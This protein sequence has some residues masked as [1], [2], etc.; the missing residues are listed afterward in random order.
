MLIV[1]CLLLFFFWEGGGVLSSCTDSSFILYVV[2]SCGLWFPLSLTTL[3]GV[4]TEHLGFGDFTFPSLN[5]Y[6]TRR[7]GLDCASLLNLLWYLS[8]REEFKMR[9]FFTNRWPLGRGR[10]C[11]SPRYLTLAV[12]AF[13]LVLQFL[14][15]GVG[16]PRHRLLGKPSPLGRRLASAGYQ[17]PG[18][19]LEEDDDVDEKIQEVAGSVNVSAQFNGKAPKKLSSGSLF[20]GRNSSYEDVAF[21][22]TRE[23]QSSVMETTPEDAMKRRRSETQLLKDRLKSLEAAEKRRNGSEEVLGKQVKSLQDAVKKQ[24]SEK[25]RLEEQ[26]KMLE[27][28]RKKDLAEHRASL[29][30]WNKFE[31]CSY[32]FFEQLVGARA[33]EAV[34]KSHSAH[35][36]SINSEKELIKVRQ[37]AKYS[38]IWIGLTKVDFSGWEWV[39]GSP[40][41]FLRWGQATREPNGDGQC[42]TDAFNDVQKDWNDIPC[43][44]L[45]KFVCKRC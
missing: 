23:N 41:R 45:Y 17:E 3:I 11:F 25:R 12:A 8:A 34:C 36:V 44:T 7:V 39:D 14:Y 1:F 4:R 37:L 43:I 5:L 2:I 32:R 24:E 10:G 31:G 33:A 29:E 27:A 16:K 18:G 22:V 38:T 15:D 21:R 26:V 19:F 28:E 9:F 6:K 13:L 20:N 42:A 30:N 40:L 35:L